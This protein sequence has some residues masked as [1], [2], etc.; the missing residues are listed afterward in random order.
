MASEDKGDQPP[1]KKIKIEEGEEV[2]DSGEQSQQSEGGSHGLKFED[3]KREEGGEEEEEGGGMEDDALYSSLGSLREADVGITEYISPNRGISAIIKQRYSDFIVNEVSL[4][5]DIVHLTDTELPVVVE[6]EEP[7]GPVDD[8]ISEDFLAQLKV[9][10]SGSNPGFVASI[11]A[12]DDKSWR[13]RLHRAVKAAFP[14]IETRTEDKEGSKVITAMLKDKVKGRGGGREKD[15]EWPS[16]C[17][18]SRFCRFT[19]YKE[20]KSTMQA[21]HA[22]AKFLRVKENKFSYAGTKDKRAKTTQEITAF[23]IHPKKLLNLN[24]FLR[25]MMLGNFSYSDKVLKLG[26]LKGNHFTIVLRNV[27]G[28]DKD[29]EACLTSLK[30]TGFINYFG[31]QRFGSLHSCTHDIGRALLREEWEKA[32]NLIIAGTGTVVEGRAYRQTWEE[33]KDPQ[34]TMKTCEGRHTYIEKRVLRALQKK[35]NDFLG[36]L[37]NLARNTRLLYPHSYQSLIWNRVTSR[38]IKTFGLKPVV[39]DL[40]LPHGAA[41]DLADTEEQES[42]EQDT[43]QKPAKKT[44]PQ[45]IVLDETTVSQYS[46][47][48]VVLPLPGFDVLYP[49]NEVRSW[50]KE[51]LEN[52]GLDIDNMRQKQKDYSLP[53]SYRPI[54]VRPTNVE[55]KI[56]HYDDVT[57]SLCLSDLDRLNGVQEPESLPDG[58]LKALRLSFTLVLSAYATMALR[59]VLKIDTSPA[60]QAS[61]NVS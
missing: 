10:A 61:M 36:A 5:G 43:D 38:R 54:V 46:I 20:N 57:T 7:P 30:N 22:I 14:N 32:V 11:P 17:R 53:G 55:W 1:L 25:N 44:R 9:V 27:L 52:D 24:K 6:E 48:D 4:S 26:E 18:T 39:G 19:L 51:M 16:S 23:K 59:E 13:L 2:T 56:F 28:E 58:K 21:I 37:Q 60:Q 34:A 15:L 31:L 41:A 50:Y 40:V 3:V 12:G 33:T 45:P 42:E 49:N 35:P 8:V 29:I 47:Y